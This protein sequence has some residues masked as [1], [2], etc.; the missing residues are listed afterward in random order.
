VQGLV[1]GIPYEALGRTTLRKTQ[2]TY[3]AELHRIELQDRVHVDLEMSR[4]S[5]VDV[6]RAERR[7]KKKAA[8]EKLSEEEKEDLA[9]EAEDEARGL[10]LAAQKRLSLEFKTWAPHRQAA[11]VRRHGWPWEE[12]EANP[13]A[14]PYEGMTAV[15][16]KELLE[17]LGSGKLDERF[18]HFWKQSGAPEVQD[19]LEAT[20]KRK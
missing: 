1:G 11:Y 12:G 17:L 5:G 9:H 6:A 7:R 13:E 10:E 16:A 19:R 4:Y 2:L 3:L 14:R 15:V 8:E 20:A 18:G